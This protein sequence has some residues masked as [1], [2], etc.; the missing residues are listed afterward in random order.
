MSSIK[1]IR[2]AS[3]KIRKHF[4][5]LEF[6]AVYSGTIEGFSEAGTLF[7]KVGNFLVSLDKP[8]S[9]FHLTDDRY[10]DNCVA[11]DLEIKVV[12]PK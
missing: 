4:N 8:S 3:K 6:W 1:V 12:V 5:T 7:I 9:F 10:I 11:V 2:D